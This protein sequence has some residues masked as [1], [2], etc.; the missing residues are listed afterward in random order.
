MQDNET[1]KVMVF[2]IV[3]LC[4]QTVAFQHFSIIALCSLIGIIYPFPFFILYF[5]LKPLVDSCDRHGI[6]A[7]LL[8][9]LLLEH[10]TFATYPIER[11]GKAFIHLAQCL[12][13]VALFS[14]CF[15]VYLTQWRSKVHPLGFSFRELW[16]GVASL[17]YP[18]SFTSKIK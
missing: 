7:F 9:W 18:S 12:G 16:I 17:S 4:W 1:E 10:R 8:A 14:C 11:V 6:R 15:G 13:W 5:L 2:A 3:V